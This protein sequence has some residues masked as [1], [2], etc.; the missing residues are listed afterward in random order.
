MDQL[1]KQAHYGIPHIVGS[2]VPSAA[3]LPTLDMYMLCY[4]Y[5]VTLFL[6]IMACVI[7]CNSE[8]APIIVL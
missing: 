2:E 1:S 5:N 3:Y 6:Q 4:F 7:V 8:S